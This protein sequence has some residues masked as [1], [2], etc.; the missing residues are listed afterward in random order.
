[1]TRLRYQFTL[2]DMPLV[3]EY[4]YQNYQRDHDEFEHY[5]SDFNQEFE[6]ALEERINAIR[7]LPSLDS[8][9][10]KVAEK[11]KKLHSG[12]ITRKP[13]KM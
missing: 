3:A 13:L 6:E 2:E 5:S 8:L 11:Q 1:M 9:D 7:E 4:I 10:E 12:E